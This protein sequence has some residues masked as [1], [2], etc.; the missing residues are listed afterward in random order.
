[1]LWVVIG[2][3]CFSSPFAFFLV[4]VILVM[5]QN[6]SLG[7]YIL[8]IRFFLKCI[9]EF[10]RHLNFVCYENVIQLR[11]KLF[12]PLT[13]FFLWQL[14][15]RYTWDQLQSNRKTQKNISKAWTLAKFFIARCKSLKTTWK[16]KMW[17]QR[18]YR[19]CC[20]FIYM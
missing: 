6:S 16:Q 20:H 19:K 10:I 11:I 1:M 12:S 13:H 5:S 3:L 2:Y 8:E 14:S 7:L 17:K 18:E 9:I 15:I 4:L